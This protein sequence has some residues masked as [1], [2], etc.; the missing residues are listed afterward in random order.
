MVWNAIQEQWSPD[1]AN[2]TI[3]AQSSAQTTTNGDIAA[4]RRNA[5]T[6]AVSI[7]SPAVVGINVTEVR[8]YQYRDPFAD[9][10]FW[11]QFFGR[12][13]PQV[14]RQQI[15]GLGSGFLI[16]PDGYILTNDHVAGQASKVVVTL[17]NGEKYDAKIVGSDPTS[18]VC[19][20]KIEGSKDQFP[21]LKF[22]NSDDILVGEWVIA[23]GN[24][25]GLFDV[26]AK[27]TV[28]VGVVSNFGVSLT[29]QDGRVYRNMIQTDAAISSGNSGGPLVN[30]NAEVVGM[31]TIIYSTAQRGG[32]AGSIGIGFAIPINRVKKIMDMLKRD[33]KIDRDFDIGLRVQQVDERIARF[34]D[35]KKAQ[36]VVVSEIAYGSPAERAGFEP[37]DIILDIDGQKIVKE[38][39]VQTVVGDGIVGQ[40]LT[41]TIM[42]NDK[43]MTK[44][45]TLTKRKR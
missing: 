12:R 35:L 1:G 24:P 26:N 5:I 23:F 44:Q 37:G 27:P 13:Q 11:G 43:K 32:E 28:T 16:S 42:R 45:L 38:N 41:F 3:Q 6:R 19:L 29:P 10:P 40:T 39:D 15:Q 33:G 18:D 34:L 9:D 36:G 21:F 31:N 20:L 17:T 2:T 25:F 7:C 30:A 8:E 14:Y 4:S 22:T